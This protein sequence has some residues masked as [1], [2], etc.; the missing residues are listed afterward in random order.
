MKPYPAYRDSGIEW[1]GKIP[2]EWK[3]SK[4]KHVLMLLYKS[5]LEAS[6]GKEEG[7]YPFFTSSIEQKKFIDFAIFDDECLIMGDGGQ[8]SINYCEGKFS[9]SSHCLVFKKQKNISLK[10]IYYQID[11]I[12][13]FLFNRLPERRPKRP[14]YPR[15]TACVRKQ[16]GNERHEPLYYRRT[17][18]SQDDPDDEKVQP[19]RS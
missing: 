9:T 11:G 18:R 7:L 1:L 15:P 4:I 6:E 12:Q 16:N 17:P 5:K 2:K 13:T 14:P 10:F 3:N 8:A 19:S